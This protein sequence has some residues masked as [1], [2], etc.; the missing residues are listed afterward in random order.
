MSEFIIRVYIPRMHGGEPYVRNCTD[1][2][3][4]IFPACAGVSLF[5]ARPA[6]SLSHIPRMRG[7]EP[8]S[9]SRTVLPLLYSPHARG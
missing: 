5:R 1:V 9:L 8:R 6:G 3:Y 7:G 4:K 2:A